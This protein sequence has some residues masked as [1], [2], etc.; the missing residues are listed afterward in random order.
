MAKKIETF[1]SRKKGR[2]EQYGW[3]SWFQMAPCVLERGED[4]TQPDNIFRAAIYK[5]ARRRDITVETV[6]VD[7]GIAIQVIDPTSVA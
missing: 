1:P 3:D 7:Y 6:I 4:Y 2:P 5:A